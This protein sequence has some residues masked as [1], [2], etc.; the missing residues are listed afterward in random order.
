MPRPLRP[1]RR[2]RCKPAS[3]S[4]SQQA[5]A[6]A[7]PEL[8]LVE[9]CRGL[10]PDG[11]VRRTRVRATGAGAAA[12]S[13][14]P[15]GNILRPTGAGRGIGRGGGEGEGPVGAWWTSR[16]G[17]ARGTSA[18]AVAAAPRRRIGRGGVGAV[19]AAAAVGCAIDT[20]GS[21]RTGRWAA[22]WE[23]L[24]SGR[25]LGGCLCLCPCLWEW[26]WGWPFLLP[27]SV[28]LVTI[29]ASPAVILMMR[30][31]REVCPLEGRSSR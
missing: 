10:V 15:E 20:I 2:R 23:A 30:G 4:S 22:G 17:S 5:A 8:R 1:P 9:A 26:G 12:R 19:A 3:S 7:P 18:R 6:A 21:G 29:V 25:L 24:G 14:A 16:R 27:S 28:H 11:S 13:S 31:G